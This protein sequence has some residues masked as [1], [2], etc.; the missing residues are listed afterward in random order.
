MCGIVGVLGKHEASPTLVEALKRLEYRGYDS[1]GIATLN[2]GH[3]DRRRAVGK[4][5]NLSDLLVHEPLPGKAGIGH[6]RWATH[7]APTLGNTHPHRAGPVAVVH[8]GI[9]E[10]Y[11]QLRAD[12]GQKGVGFDTDTDTETVALLTKLYLDLGLAPVD[13][14]KATIDRLEGAYALA[15][16]FDGEPD[17]MIAARKGSPLAIGHG[18]GEVYVGSDAIALGPFTDR[19]T[20]LEEGDIAVLT[21]ESVTITDANGELANREVRTIKIDSTQVDKGGHKHFM[22]KEIAEQPVVIGEALRHYLSDDGRDV[23]LPGAEIDFAD[24]DRMTMVAC[25]TAYYACLTAKYWFEQLAEMPVEVD[26]ASEFR[27]REPPI[28]ARNGALFVSQSGETADTL[29]AMRYCEGRAAKVLSVVNVAESSIARESDI[30]LPILA[31]T[32]I[33]VASTKAFTCQLTVLLLLALKAA[34]DRGTRTPDEIA[35]TL[36]KLR[37]LPAIINHTLELDPAFKNAARQLAE[38]ESAL[39]LG[40]GLMYPL[41]LEGALKLKEISYIHAEAYASGELKHG[42]IAL[43]DKTMPVVVM[44]PRDALFDKTVSNMQEVMA[45]GGRIV[46]VSDAAGVEAAGEGT[47]RAITM[48]VCD[49]V[50]APIL[51]AV[52]LAMAV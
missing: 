30:A 24:L 29:A 43:I 17:L 18:D 40:R 19:I 46:L 28:P 5:V 37:G 52:P 13:A 45:R 7:G 20:Y 16:L 50:L 48:P 27:Y 3:L 33:G 15:F 4:L 31:G 38:A 8:N 34:K 23:I 6:T 42:P 9:I 12:L 11:R 22:A 35:D 36:S 41:A 32:E 14:A 2:D 10:N 51:Y 47:F 26:I 39:F 49:P 21:R 1:A 44:A 25:G